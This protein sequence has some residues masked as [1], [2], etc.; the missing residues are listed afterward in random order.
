MGRPPRTRLGSTAKENKGHEL[1]GFG[2]VRFK[3]TS[4]DCQRTSHRDVRGVVR[5]VLSGEG[6]TIY[7]QN[8]TMS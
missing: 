4:S 6:M 5:G 2:D 8:K 3:G 1:A 7:A